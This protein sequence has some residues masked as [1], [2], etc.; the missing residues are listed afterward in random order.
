MAVGLCSSEVSARAQTQPVVNPNSKLDTK[1]QAVDD[2]GRS[3]SPSWLFKNLLNTPLNPNASLVSTVDSS[4]PTLAPAQAQAQLT[5]P[6]VDVALTT[7]KLLA[8]TFPGLPNFPYVPLPPLP[9]GTPLYPE[10]G[11]PPPITANPIVP[12]FPT[13]PIFSPPVTTT[14]L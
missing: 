6:H 8:P 5:P 11:L 14:T 9:P 10:Y 3:Y 13:V 7:R 1:I 2:Q 12:Y 4:P